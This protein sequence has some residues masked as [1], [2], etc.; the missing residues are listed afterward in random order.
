MLEGMSMDRWRF[1]KAKAAANDYETAL[2]S[3]GTTHELRLV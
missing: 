1:P 3:L 2:R